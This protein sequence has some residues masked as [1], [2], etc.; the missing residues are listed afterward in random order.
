MRNESEMME[1]LKKVAM[2]DERIRAAWI[3][4]SR[5]NP[6]A[7]KD[8]FQDYDVE[9]IVNDTKPFREDK[10]WIDQ[11]GERLYMQYPEENVYYED[12][13]DLEK[14][15]GWLMQ[16]S[17]GVRLDLHVCTLEDKLPVFQHN[18]M[19]RIL[20]DKD[21]CLPRLAE[22]QLSDC[23]FWV[24]KPNENEFSCTCN[25]FWWCMN[26]VAKGMWRN[27]IPYVMDML[28]NIIRPQLLQLIEWKIGIQT[29]FSVSVG[30]SGKYMYRWLNAEMYQRY[31]NTYSDAQKHK[32]WK[33]IYVMCGLVDEIATEISQNLEFSYNT[34]EARN[35]RAYLEHVQKLQRNAKEV[36]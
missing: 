26:N 20:L 24:E 33:S 5:C 34:E 1:L 12:E 14:C 23:E 21:D 2:N 3:E 36:Y 18:K 17:D 10:T 8:I 22:N 13:N 30:K 31:L 15:Y 4:G 29:N 7:P 11:F 9:F 32:I 28:N 35:S 27:E 25:E 19:Y 16:F 6:N